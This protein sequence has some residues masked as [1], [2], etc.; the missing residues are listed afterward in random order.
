MEEIFDDV[1][2]AIRETQVNFVTIIHDTKNT[3]RSS[4]MIPDMSIS[5]NST[6]KNTCVAFAI[7]TAS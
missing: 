2:F 4:A 5:L 3:S 6:K 7:L 1:V